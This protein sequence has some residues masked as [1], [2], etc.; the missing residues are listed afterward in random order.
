MRYFYNIIFVIFLLSVFPAHANAALFLGNQNIPPIIYLEGNTPAGV[1][2]DITKALAPYFNEPVEIKAM[3]WSTAQSLVMEG[4]ADVLVNINQTEER[5][6]IYDFSDSL[7][8]TKFSIFTRADRVD[9]SGLSSLYGLRVGVEKDG[10]PDQLLKINPEIK[11]S[12][13]PNFNDGFKQLRDGVLDAVVVD[14]RVGSYILAKYS[15]NNIRAVEEPLAFSYSAFAVKKGNTVLLDKI[16]VALL[17]LKKN[18]VYQAI[19]NKWQ[20]TETIFQTQQQVTHSIY[21]IVIFILFILSIVVIAWSTTINKELTRRRKAENYSE[22]LIS[23]A[24]AMIMVLDQDGKVIVFNEMAEKITG[25]KKNEV[26]GRSWFD[27]AIPSSQFP[28]MWK[29]FD[30]FKKQGKSISGDFKN[31][32]LTKNG[33]KRIIEW[34]NSDLKDND[35]IVGTISFGIDI[36]ERLKAEESLQINDERFRA[37]QTLSKVG[38]WEYN[39]KTTQFWASDEAKHIYGLGPDI[40]DFSTDEVE[41]CIPER[42]RVHQA[43]VDLIE[44]NKE[45]NLEFKIIPKDSTK[46]KIITSI[47]KLHRDEYGKPLKVTGVIQDITERKRVEERLKEL[48]K[49]KDDFLMIT[50]HELKTPLVPIKSQCQLLLAGEYGELNDE[51]KSALE[52]IYR[53]EEALGELTGEVLDVAKIKSNKMQIIRTETSLGK[54]ITNIVNDLK[55]LA[56]PKHVILSLVALPELPKVRVDGSRI[57]QALANLIDNAIKFTPEGGSVVVEVQKGKDIISITITDSGIGISA[58]NI[59]KL[60]EPFFQIQRDYSRKQRG[61][62]LGLAVSKGLIMAHGGTIKVE[63]AGEGKGST[64]IVTLPLLIEQ[65]K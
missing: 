57:R 64:F 22:K 14:Y 11:I 7:L 12:F 24:N 27:L 18:G 10:L 16:N 61:T 43:L 20:P 55:T 9:I 36:T 52:M 65:K 2:V 4:E 47:A 54:I 30:E 41:K 15:I 26:I 42:E 37:A 49:L 3:D 31:P 1:A 46:P 45:Y 13:I 35:K 63:S 32:I 59:P 29:L 62:G 53:N 38:N 50:T 56:E 19:L 23:L 48:D 33:D 21:I 5:K 8:E 17:T 25:Y 34:R 44:K 51:Q 6:K 28:D 60:F 58:D 40:N 39:I